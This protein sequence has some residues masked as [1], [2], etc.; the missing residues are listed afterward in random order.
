MFV[1]TLLS[2]VSTVN[3]LGKGWVA[4]VKTSFGEDKF[5]QNL[6]ATVCA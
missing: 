5:R 1:K 4:L 3:E 2:L 6:G